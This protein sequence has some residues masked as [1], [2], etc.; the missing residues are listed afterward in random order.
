MVVALLQLGRRTT[1]DI[2]LP[3]TGTQ[4]ASDLLRREFPPE[5]NSASPIVFHVFHG[6]LT[7]AGNRRAMEASLERM[8]RQ[9]HVYSVISP[10]SQAGAAAISAIVAG[11]RPGPTERERHGS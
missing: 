8:A 7:D 10:F 1:N 11:R 6:K 5:Q 9:P 3:G 4:Q 2:K